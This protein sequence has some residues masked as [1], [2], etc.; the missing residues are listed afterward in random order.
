VL[1]NKSQ[2][3][4]KEYKVILPNE[5]ELKRIIEDTKKAIQ[6]KNKNNF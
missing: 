4:S 5:K 6:Q 1:S 3:F 2:I